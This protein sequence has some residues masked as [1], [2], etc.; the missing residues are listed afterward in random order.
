MQIYLMMASQ[1]T[2]TCSACGQP[3][4]L[5]GQHQNQAVVLRQEQP[6][7]LPSTR[8]P[9]KVMT[10]RSVQRTMLC[11]FELGLI[12]PTLAQ[13]LKSPTCRCGE[14]TPHKQV[15]QASS[16]RQDV[17]PLPLPTSD[18]LQPAAAVMAEWAPR[19]D[20][21][22]VEYHPQANRLLEFSCFK[23]FKKDDPLL[24]SGGATRTSHIDFEFSEFCAEASLNTKQVDSVLELVQKIAADPAQLSSKLASDV[25]V[26]WE[27]AKSH[28]PAF[29]KSIIEVPYRKGTLEFDVHTRSSWQWALALIKDTTLAQHITWHAVKQFKFTDGEWVRFWDEPNT[30]D[31][32]W[33]VQSELPAEGYPVAFILYADKTCLLSFGSHKGYPIV[34]QLANLPSEIHDGEGY[35]GGQVVGFLPVVEDE[36]EEGKLGY[37][38][39]KRVVWHKA[40]WVLLKELAK[41]YSIG[42]K[43]QCGDNIEHVLY[44]VILILSADYEEQAMMSLIHGPNGLAPCPIC[45]VPKDQ[46]HVI[47][48]PPDTAYP[49]QDYQEVQEIVEKHMSAGA[50]EALLQPLGIRPV[51]ILVPACYNALPTSKKR[52]MALLK[53]IRRYNIL[54][55][56]SGLIVQTERTLESYVQTLVKFVWLH[57][58]TPELDTAPSV[59]DSSNH[60]EFNMAIPCHKAAQTQIASPNNAHLA[61]VSGPAPV[62]VDAGVV[63][64]PLKEKGKGKAQAATV[65]DC[66]SYCHGGV[67]GGPGPGQ[68]DVLEYSV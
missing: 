30:A 6:L 45:L 53:V 12:C 1:E 14:G 39:L 10:L 31:Y 36:D 44:P 60:S 42:Q 64:L 32:W 5:G 66:C 61:N 49:L 15:F 3:F 51:H 16:L 29:E 46:Q 23:D 34:A 57:L 62:Q 9:I 67:G 55:L 35:G 63:Q 43:T 21:F 13:E 4:R 24:P 47:H 26:A 25:H 52:W 41:V 58:R 48:W 17:A 68:G 54:D 33:D 56:Y 37:T 19:E 18:V 20:N 59:Q 11:L 2:S 38:N 8:E 7:P 28:Q 27:N 40:F 65:E 50:K 22:K